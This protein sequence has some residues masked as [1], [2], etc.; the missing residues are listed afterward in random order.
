MRGRSVPESFSG[1][2][3]H[4]QQHRNRQQPQMHVAE[5]LPKAKQQGQQESRRVESRSDVVAEELWIAEDVAGASMSDRRTT[6]RAEGK[7]GRSGKIR[8][9]GRRSRSESGAVPQTSHH[10]LGRE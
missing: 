5:S 9:T 2:K 1:R 3:K 4:G 10:A 6:R 8:R 7:G